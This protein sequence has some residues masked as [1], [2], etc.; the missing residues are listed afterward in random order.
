VTNLRIVVVVN[1]VSPELLAAL[2]GLPPRSRAER[3]R[4]LATLGLSVFGGR[5]APEAVTLK[6][7]PVPANKQNGEGRAIAFAKALGGLE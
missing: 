1:E 5:G 3:I 7:P 2:E 6:A 4:T